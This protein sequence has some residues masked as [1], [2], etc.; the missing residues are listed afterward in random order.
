MPVSSPSDSAEALVRPKRVSMLGNITWMGF[1]SAAVKPLWFVF[2]TYFCINMLGDEGYGV[3]NWALITMT[4]AAAFGD[5]GT[6]SYSTRE[7]ARHPDA[8]SHYFTNFLLVRLL[9]SVTVMSVILLLEMRSG[10]PPNKLWALA[11]GGVYT[12]GLLLLEY[13]RTFY[14]AFE[15]LRYEAIS[16]VVEKVLVVGLGLTL[17]W[18]THTPEGTLTGMAA[19]MLLALSANVVWISRRLAPFRPQLI[20]LAFLR[21]KVGAALP[22]GIY[23]LLG[24]VYLRIGPYLLE[25]M[26]GEA[27]LGRFSVAYRVIEALQL[28]PAIVAAVALPRLSSLF[29]HRHIPAFRRLMMQSTLALFGLALLCTIGLV[30]FGPTITSLLSQGKASFAASGDLLQLLAWAFPLMCVN[31]FMVVLL[32]AANEQ[33]FLAWVMSGMVLCAFGANLVFIPHYGAG[34]VA[35]IIIIF[36]ALLCTTY[37][38]RYRVVIHRRA[39]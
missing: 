27:A 10:E 6:G 32:I 15:V 18:L 17:L 8:A 39:K 5:M 22:I 11:M 23:S 25:M 26:Q 7:V 37:L 28:L 38:A 33:R 16:M 34:A 4:V 12:T 2:I 31:G 36:E 21:S 29:G 24:V 1:G 20:T 19:G 3:L 30:L 35:A 9:A 13:C 14:R